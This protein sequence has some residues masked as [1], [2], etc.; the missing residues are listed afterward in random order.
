[1]RGVSVV[2]TSTYLGLPNTTVNVMRPTRPSW[3]SPLTK[4][5]HPRLFT[6]CR[7]IQICLMWVFIRLLSKNITRAYDVNCLA[8]F[9][10]PPT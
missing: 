5:N 9:T 6:A 1:M 8:L 10:H 7:C 2:G 4:A 3:T